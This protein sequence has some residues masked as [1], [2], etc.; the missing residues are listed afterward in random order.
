MKFILALFLTTPVF[1]ARISQVSVAKYDNGQAIETAFDAANSVTYKNATLTTSTDPFAGKTNKYAEAAAIM[2]TCNTQAAHIKF[3]S[4]APT[5]TVSDFYIPV[6]WPMIF[7][8]D[9]TKAFVALIQD[10]ASAVCYTV[11]LK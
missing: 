9:P 8:I 5:A 10:A 7:K 6:N 11:E 4:S 3:G 2:V 1:A